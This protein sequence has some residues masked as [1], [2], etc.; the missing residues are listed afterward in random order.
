MPMVD[1]WRW[2]GGDSHDMIFS[3]ASEE[4]DLALAKD[5]D[6]AGLINKA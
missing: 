3:Q 6:A 5:S 1:K 4:N 2:T